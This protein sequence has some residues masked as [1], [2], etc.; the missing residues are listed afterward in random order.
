MT[1]TLRRATRALT[2]LSIAALLSGCFT[3]AQPSHTSSS[4]TVF[5]GYASYQSPSGSISVGVYGR[6][7][8]YPINDGSV[9]YY[10]NHP[11]PTNYA[12]GQFC[13]QADSHRHSYTPYRNHRYVYTDGHYFW[14]GD[15]KPYAVSGHRYAYSGHHP[16]PHYFGGNCRIRGLHQ[17]A[18]A[19]G[20]RDY[21]HLKDGSYYFTGAYDPDYYANRGRYDVRGWLEENRAHGYRAHQDVPAQRRAATANQALPVEVQTGEEIIR[22]PSSGSDAADPSSRSRS[23]RVQRPSRN[24]EA[25]GADPAAEKRS[26]RQYKADSIRDRLN[27]ER[28][29]EISG[30]A[31]ANGSDD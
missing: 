23:N 26:I 8:H 22:E 18:Y 11:H 16:H 1:S 30:S 14:I 7:P 28:T 20:S 13:N 15:A 6:A 10:G 31:P 3:V 29:R 27:R 2:A 25:A 4:G 9:W 5:P 24:A 21:Y 19:P 17:H 12:K